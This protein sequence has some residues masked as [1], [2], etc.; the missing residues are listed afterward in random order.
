MRTTRSYNGNVLLSVQLRQYPQYQTAGFFCVFLNSGNRKQ[1][2]RKNKTCS[3]DRKE[4]QSTPQNRGPP[5]PG[6]KSW[7]RHALR[8]QAFRSCRKRQYFRTSSFF[9]FSSFRCTLLNSVI[10]EC[11]RFCMIL[12]FLQT[13]DPLRQIRQKVCRDSR[14][15]R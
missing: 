8:S 10:R 4:Q 3:A 12:C 2:C 5:V 9:S 11:I 14:L 15:Q 6:T 13:G 1:I 7:M